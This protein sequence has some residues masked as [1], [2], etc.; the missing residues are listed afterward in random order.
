M[1]LVSPE[2]AETRLS[3]LLAAIVVLTLVLAFAYAHY[4]LVAPLHQ[5]REAAQAVTAHSYTPGR[6][7]SL[8]VRSDDVG[9][10]SRS[11]EAMMQR[12]R[13]LDEHR[14]SSQRTTRSPE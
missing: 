5:L 8:S 1:S 9:H 14:A 7:A 6:L 2:R 10:L 12:L 4:R 3:I 13:D 11:F